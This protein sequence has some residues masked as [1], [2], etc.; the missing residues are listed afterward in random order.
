MG[1]EL[2]SGAFLATDIIDQICPV[3]EGLLAV[4]WFIVLEDGI[5]FVMDAVSHR[6]MLLREGRQGRLNQKYITS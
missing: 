1:S 2:G 4:L 5:E 3:A 6:L